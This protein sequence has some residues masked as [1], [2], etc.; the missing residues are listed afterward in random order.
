MTPLRLAAVVLLCAF[1]TGQE[2]LKYA[3]D[4]EK[5]FRVVANLIVDKNFFLL[6]ELTAEE[7]ETGQVD[8]AD[9]FDEKNRKVTTPAPTTAAPTTTPAP[10]TKAPARFSFQ[11]F[12]GLLPP[13][14]AAPARASAGAA[15]G[16]PGGGRRPG[17][18]FPPRTPAPAAVDDAQLE[19]ATTEAPVR[20][21][22]SRRKVVRGPARP[23]SRRRVTAA[24]TTEAP[25]TEAPARE[26]PATTEAAPAPAS[27]PRRSGNRRRKPVVNRR[28]VGTVAPPAPPTPPAPAPAAPAPAAPEVRPASRRRVTAGAAAPTTPALQEPPLSPVA[29]VRR[30]PATSNRR[31]QAQDTREN[32]INA[33]HRRLPGGSKTVLKDM[34]PSTFSCK[35]RPYGYYADIQADCQVFHIC[36]PVVHA[37]GFEQNLKH[38]LF[39]NNGTRFDQRTLTCREETLALPCDRSESYYASVKYFEKF[40]IFD[41]MRA[42]DEKKRRRLNNRLE[43]LDDVEALEAQLG[44]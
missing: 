35:D 13:P 40:N 27:P 22:G 5:P 33:L 34:P 25:T 9:P 38:S 16:R 37:D 3:K 42:E 43:T 6:R 14:P 31:P 1:V 36:T 26:A 32:E 7:Q 28:V 21:G 2:E 8:L 20:R 19:L 24:P 15:T 17:G 29:S 39:C 10:T 44:Q 41:R 11:D 4:F 30:I 12:A 18:R 23:G